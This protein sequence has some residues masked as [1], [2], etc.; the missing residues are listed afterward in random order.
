MYTID[1]KELKKYETE[2]DYKK[3]QDPYVK[4]MMNNIE[5]IFLDLFD[6]E[7]DKA[8]LRRNL[9]VYASEKILSFHSNF[10]ENNGKTKDQFKS[11]SKE[12]INL[13][14]YGMASYNK[15][16]N[17]DNLN[18]RRYKSYTFN[19][20]KTHSIYSTSKI[21]GFSEQLLQA[22]NILLSKEDFKKAY[23]SDLIPEY[24]YRLSITSPAEI[25]EP[26]KQ[27]I[28]SDKDYIE[29]K[30]KAI[31]DEKINPI[32]EHCIN[33]IIELFSEYGEMKERPRKKHQNDKRSF[34]IKNTVCFNL[35]ILQFKEYKINKRNQITPNLK[36]LVRLDDAKQFDKK[37][38]KKD[39]TVETKRMFEMGM[40]SGY[41]H[42]SIEIREFDFLKKPA[43]YAISMTPHGYLRLKK[44]YSKEFFKKIIYHYQFKK[45]FEKYEIDLNIEDLEDPQVFFDLV[46]MMDY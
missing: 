32:A 19:F 17:N 14:S 15:L 22:P 10:V 38:T 45:Y 11:K 42:F 41:K 8:S 34:F 2:N 3:I 27:K 16:Y 46:S 4:S 31:F 36:I 23:K 7:K 35:E 26:S 29:N 44:E 9:R 25:G 20:E 5:S 12:D 28:F 1:Y 30:F 37:I 39:G 33:E 18:E 24:N 40:K 6:Y 13:L 21:Y 43:Y